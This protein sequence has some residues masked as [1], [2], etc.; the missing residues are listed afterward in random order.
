MKSVIVLF[1][2]VIVGSFELYAQ[3]PFK[4][5]YQAVVRDDQG[6]IVANEFVALR[7]TIHSETAYGA[8]VYQEIQNV[9]T[10]EFG[11]VN[12]VIGDGA[13]IQGTMNTPSWAGLTKFLQVEI[14]IGN[15]YV[16]LGSN[17]LNSV[18]YA[19]EADHV[20]L[21]LD[22]LTDVNLGPP[23]DNEFLVY[24]V[25][26]WESAQVSEALTAGPGITISNNTISATGDLNT[27]DD[28][29][30]NLSNLMNTALNTDIVPALGSL[31]SLGYGNRRFWQLYISSSIRMSYGSNIQMDEVDVFIKGPANEY[32]S[33]MS[34]GL[35]AGVPTTGYD[36]SFFGYYS[37]NS[38]S[39]GIG[40]S[41]FGAN[42][43]SD[44]STG[45]NN[46]TFGTNTG[47]ELAPETRTVISVP[48]RGIMV[49]MLAITLIWVLEQDVIIQLETTTY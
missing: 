20:N 6:E 17:Q 26:H 24:D 8:V 42:S 48:M 2:F 14:N 19:L 27:L 7:F 10:N 37:G 40:N 36:N 43:G 30:I 44:L 38:I 18:P 29:N 41:C 23:Q 15:G 28:A 9:N 21:T 4:F 32:D 39:T 33:D 35:E 31:I 1:L 16:D 34:F 25:D 49:L 13:P 12:V 47:Y 5:N 46:C 3:V 11:L 45:T 22:E